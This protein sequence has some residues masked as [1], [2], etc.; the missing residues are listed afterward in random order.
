[1]KCVGERA[2]H[3]RIGVEVI[4][5]YLILPGGLPIIHTGEK[6]VFKKGSDPGTIKI[7]KESSGYQYTGKEICPKPVVIEDIWY[8]TK[9]MILKEQDI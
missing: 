8:A 9:G 5:D 3:G 1:M 7:R 2:V 6:V 4:L